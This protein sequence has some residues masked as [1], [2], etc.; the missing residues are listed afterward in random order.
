MNKYMVLSFLFIAVISCGTSYNTR[1]L[2]HEQLEQ[3]AEEAFLQSD[4]KD[5]T[6]LYTELMFTYPGAANTDLYLF[7]LG[8]SEAGMRYWADALFYFNRVQ[9]EYS[10]SVWADDCS[11]QSARAWWFQRHDYRKDLNPVLHCCDELNEFFVEYPGSPLT[12]EA[13]ALMDSANCF[14]S[15]RALFVGQ[16]YARRHKYDASLLYLNEALN[17]YGDTE[18]KAEILIALGTVYADKGNGH[19]ARRF[20]QRALDECD[21]NE[22]QL[23]EVQTFLEE[24]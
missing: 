1:G 10:R 16:F 21:L 5:A 13:T 14:L 4:F 11:F 23:R 3:L 7:R 18:S 19:S 8:T 22:D 20:Y 12:E 24:L 9:S 6:R 17:D 2:N 15:M